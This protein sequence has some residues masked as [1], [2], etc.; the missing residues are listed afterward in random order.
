MVCTFCDNK[1]PKEDR[2]FHLCKERE[3]FFDKENNISFKRCTDR[4]IETI[5][6]MHMK[7]EPI[8]LKF[9]KKVLDRI[10]KLG[11]TEEDLENLHHYITHY[12]PIIVHMRAHSHF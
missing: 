7:F 9:H 4:Q 10:R 11:Y 2:P 6:Y 5:L 1:V 3:A 8:H 12:A